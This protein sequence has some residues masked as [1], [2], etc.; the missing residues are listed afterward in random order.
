MERFGVSQCFPS[1]T[2]DKSSSQ[3]R[4]PVTSQSTFLLA[5]SS[6]ASGSLVEPISQALSLIWQQPIGSSSCLCAS[7]FYTIL[8]DSDLDRLCCTLLCWTLD[9]SPAEPF[10]NSSGIMHNCNQEFII[11]ITCWWLVATI[12]DSSIMLS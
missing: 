2:V 4:S 3:Q 8:S 11:I 12:I 5:A 9:Q 1:A 6:V 7:M 10:W